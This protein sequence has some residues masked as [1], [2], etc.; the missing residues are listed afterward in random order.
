[1]PREKIT[2][3]NCGKLFEAWPSSNRKFCSRKC[4]NI[5]QATIGGDAKTRIY[6][7]W[8]SMQQR[9]YHPNCKA[10]RHYGGRGIRVCKKWRGSY[11]NFRSWAMANGYSDNLQIDRIDNN[12]GYSPQNCRFVTASQNVVNRRKRKGT[13][14]RYRGI[15]WH[16][17][18]KKWRA[19]IKMNGKRQYLGLFA[20]QQEAARAY[21]DAA[22][23]L[24]GRFAMLNFSN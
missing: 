11:L 10:Y 6:R 19:S 13:R 12:K 2:C 3:K 16:V 9:C 8:C 23:K 24:H 1:M 18:A 22:K 7:V 4:S 14:S 20:T 21:D 17:R 15:D 5:E